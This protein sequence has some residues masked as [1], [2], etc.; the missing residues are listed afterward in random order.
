M[1]IVHRAGVEGVRSGRTFDRQLRVLLP[2][3]P[4]AGVEAAFPP[5]EVQPVEDDAGRDAR[6]RSRRRARRPAARG[7]RLVPRRVQRT[8]DAARAPGRRGSA[9][10]ASGRRAAR[11]RRRARRVRAASSVALDRVVGSRL[12]REPRPV[13]PPPRPRAAARATRPGRAPRTPRARSAAAATRDARR[14]RASR[15]RRR[16]TRARCPA[17]EAAAAK[18]LGRRQRVASAGP[19]RLCQVTLDVQERRARD[20]TLEVGPAAEAPGRRATSG[21]RRRR[22]PR[23]TGNHAAA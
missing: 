22:S 20:V 8:G 5:G 15:R 21:S 4:R 14:R 10:R 23:V 1:P 2:L 16:A 11:R 17:R 6:S 7:E 3:R 18:L 19:G 9:R 13:R 12:G